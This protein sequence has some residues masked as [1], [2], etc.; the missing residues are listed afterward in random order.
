MKKYCFLLLLIIFLS[1]LEI[2]LPV[3]A[4][5]K[6][7]IPEFRNDSI[8][9][10]YINEADPRLIKLKKGTS[11]LYAIKKY[12]KLQTVEYAEL[13]Y[14]VNAQAVP[15]D[16]SYTNQWYLKRINAPEAWDIN[17]SSPTITIAIVDSGVQI[18]HPDLA[19]VLWVNRQ[20]IAGNKKDDDKNGLVDDINGWDFVNKVADPSPKFKTGFSEAGV[21]HGTIIAGIAAAAGNNDQ[22]ISGV[23]WKSNIM[24]LKA[25]DDKGSGDIAA[26]VKAV[27]YATAKG[28]NIINLSFITFGFSKSL[29]Q[30]IIKARA[31]GVIV[32]APA[33]NEQQSSNGI[34]L[35]RR[36]V[37][38]ACYRDRAGKK[39]V[40]GVAATDGLDQKT[41]FSGYGNS[42]IDIS[43]PG[44]SFYSTTFFAPDKSSAG[45]FF[46]QYYDGYWSGT[47]MAVP[48]VTGA[49]ALVQGTNPSLSPDQS[50][51]VLLTSTD[52]INN[53]NPDYVNQ[54]G[55]G[56]LNVAQ[57]VLQAALQLKNRR[58]RFAF[59]SD[60]ISEPLVT[61]SD[62]KGFVE[63]TFLAYPVEFNGGVNLTRADVN[64]DGTE[65]IIT[66]PAS[67][68][69]ADVRIFNDKGT[70]LGHFLALPANFRRGAMVA[71]ADI[72][73]DGK[74]EIIVTPASG[75]E[76]IIKIYKGNGV[77]VR[78]FTAFPKNFQ[79][80]V[81]IAVADIVEGGDQEIIVTPSKDF[82]PQVKVFSN[83]GKLL[84]SFIA[85]PKTYFGG[86]NLA[87]ADVDANPRQRAAEIILSPRSGS[88]YV[89]IYDFRGNQRLRFMPYND[90]FKGNTRIIA[91][92]LN[93]DGFTDIITMPG[94]GAGPHVRVFNRSGSLLTSFYAYESLNSGGVR[95]TVFLTK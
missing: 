35:N 38:P 26:V 62:S 63:K 81:Q 50:L 46:N 36:P 31:D 49:L 70:M 86:L 83:S 11:P 80:G 21:L 4:Q 7:I 77:L 93:R 8:I 53:L 69:E 60:S 61:I 6:E 5:E 54:L 28:A 43:A 16:Q 27:D 17:N 64:G 75:M 85:G 24:A 29:E 9:V 52:N 82:S 10:K 45:K 18:T 57:A 39:L 12:E 66:V 73:G 19:P 13:N 37:Y 95:A 76:S 47:S 65:E 32:I 44:V 68:R 91:S 1:P 59:T 74:D 48:L 51:S 67:G 58:A 33:G 42:C 55:S 71:G 89:A 84:S 20:E 30:S 3:F 88:S 34:D 90:N 41:P 23:T 25:L 87:S 22:G 14:I 78:S 92:D 2:A 94:A 56:R 79:S 15:S 72:D 40:V